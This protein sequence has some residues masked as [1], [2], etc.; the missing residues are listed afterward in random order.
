MPT[1][2]VETG[3]Q[4]AALPWRERDGRLE[5]LLITSRQSKRWIIP[6]GWPI[7]DLAPHASAEQEAMEEAGIVGR[8]SPTVL[9]SFYYAKGLKSG[10]SI[11]CKVIVFPLAVT[12]MR[13]D[14]PEK[15][16]RE[17]RW[18]TPQEAVEAV[19]ETD[20]RLLIRRFVR[21]HHAVAQTPAGK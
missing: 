16:A 6:K 12:R 17:L 13:R 9:G 14:W 18:H 11:Q 8:I 19:A 15:N 5:I 21:Q 3:L 20:L 4:Y 2:R 10:R 1:T 7:E